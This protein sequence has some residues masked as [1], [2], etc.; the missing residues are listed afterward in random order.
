MRGSAAADDL[1]FDPPVERVDGVV[2]AA[3]EGLH[4]EPAVLQAEGHDVAEGAGHVPALRVAMPVG[5]C[6]LS[7]P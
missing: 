6:S 2:G 4:V 1:E 5:R 7:A 3:E